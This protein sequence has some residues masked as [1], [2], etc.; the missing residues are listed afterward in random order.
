M[1][2]IDTFT[3]VPLSDN[4]AREYIRQVETKYIE[5]YEHWISDGGNDWS[6]FG[7]RS[8]PLRKRKSG[9]ARPDMIPYPELEKIALMR[10]RAVRESAKS[11]TDDDFPPLGDAFYDPVEEYDNEE[12]G[13]D[14]E[15]GESEYADDFDFD[16]SVDEEADG[17]PSGEPENEP[18][19]RQENKEQFRQLRPDP[20]PPVQTR[21][22]TERTVP[23]RSALQNSSPA[24]SAAASDAERRRM[25]KS[26]RPAVP[27]YDGKRQ[28]FSERGTRQGGFDVSKMNRD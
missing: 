6:G 11:D 5:D 25:K 4:I 10:S 15:Y 1:P 13:D 18:G 8:Q 16:G 9:V 2:Q 17:A 24:Q 28:S 27:S 26:Q 7:Y 23:D 22:E 19:D 20:I 3:R 12:A 21:R 14:S